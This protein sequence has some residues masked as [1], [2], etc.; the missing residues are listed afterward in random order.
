MK[1]RALPQGR[2]QLRLRC[3]DRRQLIRWGERTGCPLTLRRCLAVAK[4]ASGQSRAQAARQLLCATSTV[5]SAVQ[6]FQKSG[7]EGLSDGR[8]QNGRRKVDERFRRTLCRV[9]EG[10]PQQSGWRRTTWT[11]ELLAREVERRG[12]VRVSPATMGRALASVG[13]RRRRPR[14]VVRCPWPARRRQRRLWQLKCHAALARPDEPVLFED[15]MDV[16]L[17]PKI[18]PDWTLPGQRREVVTPGNNQKRFVAGAL[19][20][21]T[22]RVTWVQGEKKTSA[23]FI[24]LVRAVDAAY[25]R[26]KRLHFILDNA[27]THSSKKALEALGERLVLHFLPPYCPEGNRIECLWWDVH[28]NVTRNHRCKRIEALMAE[29]DAYLDARNTRKTAS[30]LLRTAPARHA[31]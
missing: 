28:A 27:A 16:H 15:E 21:R 10:T 31:A 6:R 17:N 4:V 19:D 14:P 5:V 30:P 22:A 12:R 8:A 25:P 2:Q 3:P 13:A 23:L 20:A 1:K 7:R 11:R 18:G 26:A 24:D 9:L 29:V